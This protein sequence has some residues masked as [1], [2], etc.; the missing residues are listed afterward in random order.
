MQFF[1]YSFSFFLFLGTIIATILSCKRFINNFKILIQMK[2]SIFLALFLIGTSGLFAQNFS[3]SG[4]QKLQAGFNFYGHGTG[5]KATYDYGL[6]DQFSIGVGGVFYNSGDYNSKFF[7]FGRA[8]YHFAEPINL[9]EQWDTYLGVELGLV[10]DGEF[11]LG[12]H[13]GARYALSDTFS[14]FVE[15]GNNGAVGIALNL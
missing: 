7:V 4:D 11:G 15:A 6:G 8:D 1:L 13:L 10:G 3:G 2:K 5:I 14:I 9:P 12:G